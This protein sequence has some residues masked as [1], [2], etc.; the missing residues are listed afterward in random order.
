[1]SLFHYVTYKYVV[2]KDKRLGIA[3]YL[4]AA[5]ILIY[6]SVQIVLNKAYLKVCLITS[7]IITVFSYNI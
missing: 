5:L 6:T 3:Y 2:I 4:L 7:I 1:M